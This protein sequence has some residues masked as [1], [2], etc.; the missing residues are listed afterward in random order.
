MIEDESQLLQVVLTP[1]CARIHHTHARAHTHTHT[2]TSKCAVLK[3]Q[4]ED[5]PTDEEL[6]GPRVRGW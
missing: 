2:Q 3:N 1:V 6:Q 4:N 5:Y